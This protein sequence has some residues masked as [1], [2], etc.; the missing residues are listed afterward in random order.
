MG[1][2]GTFRILNAAENIER[3]QWLALWHEWPSREVFAH[4]GYV[5]LFSPTLDRATCAAWSSPTGGVL[6][7]LILRSIDQEEW[8]SGPDGLVDLAGP[9]G[10][11]GPF[12]WGDVDDAAFWRE[13][14]RWANSRRVVSCF[15]RLSLFGDEI[16]SPTGC[17]QLNAPNVV[18]SLHL[19]PDALWMDYEHKVRKNVKRAQ[20]EGVYVEV[21]ASAAR[22]DDF[23]SIYNGTMDRRGASPAYYFDRNFFLRLIRDLEGQFMFFHALHDGALVSTELVLVSENY[24]YSFLGGTKGEAFELRSNDL[25]K[26]EIILWGQRSGKRAFV[27]GGGY[28]GPDGIF[29]YKL[30]FAPKGEVPFR[31]SKM[32][33]E[34]DAYDRLVAMRAAWEVRQ[35]R[36]WQPRPGFFPAYRA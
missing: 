14:Q 27:L 11:G 21:D 17:E 5:G 29:R 19:A 30:S 24:I 22:L 28:G 36:E 13:F 25:L 3:E 4:P 23:F 26:H 35:G 7:P 12:R 10:Y 2:S 9:Y 34:C 31:T 33:F 6:F 15:T 32:V 16:L 20:R 18:R 1:R 8:A